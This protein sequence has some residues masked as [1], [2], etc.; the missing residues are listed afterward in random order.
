[1]CMVFILQAEDIVKKIFGIQADNIG[2]MSSSM[3]MA[4]G[5]ALVASKFAKKSWWSNSKGAGKSC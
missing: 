2:K 1:M 3:A 5:G 4:A